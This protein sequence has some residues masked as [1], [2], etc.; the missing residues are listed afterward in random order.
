[1]LFVLGFAASAFAVHA[2]IPSETTATVAKGTTQITVGGEIRV[3]GEIRKNTG[4]FD[5]D[6]KTDSNGR[7]EGANW[8]QRVR[9]SIQ[10]DVSKNTTGLVQLESGDSNT[11]DNVTWG[12]PD[13]AAKGGYPFGNSKK[14]DLRILQAWIQHSGSGL[15]GI[16]AGFKVGHMPLKLG[17]GLF[18]DHTK[19]GDDAL[20]LFATPSKG[21]ELGLGSA[22]FGE[23]NN[24]NA[25]DNDAYF[26]LVSYA[27]NKDT[28]VGADVTYVNRQ[29]HTAVAG[30]ENIDTHFW[31]FGLRGN[32]TIAGLGLKAGLEFQAGKDHDGGADNKYRGYA[33][34]LGADYKLAPVT[35]SAAFAYGSGDDDATDNKTKLF[36]TSL[37]ADQ[38]FTYVYEYSTVN[39]AGQLSGGIANTMYAKIGANA[40]VMKDLNLDLAAYWLRAVKKVPVVLYGA[41]ATKGDSKNIGI[42]FDAKATYKLDRNLTYWVEGGYL[43]AGA[44]FDT[45]TTKSDNAYALRHGIMLSF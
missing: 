14:G 36:V 39:A 3:R 35:L 1:M 44:F 9:L 15:L 33:F 40:D 29:N 19:F 10:A 13:N 22:K 28:N 41:T 16:P 2:D 42:E 27:V 34:L 30:E 8:D 17:Y 21:L 5:N 6:V 38:H 7:G 32:T 11:A 23:G 4:D 12:K 43:F 31:N 45:A 20:Y 18:F 25:D 24:W 26:A 37:G